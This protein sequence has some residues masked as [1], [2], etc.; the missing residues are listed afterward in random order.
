SGGRGMKRCLLH[1][2][3]RFELFVGAAV[4]ANNLLI[5]ADLVQRRAAR[6]RRAPC[7]PRVPV[8]TIGLAGD[9]S[10]RPAFFRSFLPPG[11]SATLLSPFENAARLRRVAHSQMPKA[12]QCSREFRDRN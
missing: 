7:S 12:F 2:R 3:E 9:V 6:R 4:L 10:P 5:A 1:G 11:A 8:T